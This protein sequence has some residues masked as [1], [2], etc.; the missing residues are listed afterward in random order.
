MC[1]FHVDVNMAESV[2]TRKLKLDSLLEAR[3]CA[4]GMGRAN[5]RGRINR[6]SAR[7]LKVLDD[8]AGGA[9]RNDAAK[10]ALLCWAATEREAWLEAV[11]NDPLLLGTILPFDYLATT[12][13][14]ELHFTVKGDELPCRTVS[15]NS[16]NP[17]Q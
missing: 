1:Q 17:N 8:R 14:D 6:R 4:G 5:R 7:H 15:P 9:L 2:N 13:A 11:T 12:V 3:P 10:K 16:W